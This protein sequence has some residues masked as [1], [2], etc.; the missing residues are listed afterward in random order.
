MGV[1]AVTDHK[2]PKPA[3]ELLDVG[4]GAGRAP[5]GKRCLFIGLGLVIGRVG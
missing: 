1:H 5:S 3:N 4:L 2:R